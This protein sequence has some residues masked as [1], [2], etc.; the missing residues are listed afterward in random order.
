MGHKQERE[1]EI[2]REREKEKKEK[3]NGTMQNNNRQGEYNYILNARPPLGGRR[4]AGRDSR[5]KWFIVW[6]VAF[7]I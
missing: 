2:E 4:E 5:F 1:R 7:T 3:N 6:P